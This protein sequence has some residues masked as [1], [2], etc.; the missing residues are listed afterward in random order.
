[1]LSAEKR[2]NLD[3]IK[4]SDKFDQELLKAWD[5]ILIEQVNH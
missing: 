1:M 4:S 5:S 3:K 2:C